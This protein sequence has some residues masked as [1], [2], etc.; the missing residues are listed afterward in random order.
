MNRSGWR[1]T[2]WSK[3]IYDMNIIFRYTSKKD[4]LLLLLSAAVIL[5]QVFVETWIPSQMADISN[6][7]QQPGTGFDSVRNLGLSMLGAAFTAFALAVV[8]MILLSIVGS[9][10][11]GQVRKALFE[12][13]IRFSQ[14]DA[15]NFGTGSLINRATNDVTVVQYFIS[16]YFQPLI[17][18]PLTLFIVFQRMMKGYPVWTWL[19]AV[20]ILVLIGLLA[21]MVAAALPLV[22]TGSNSRD[23]IATLSRE[24]VIGIR[25][26]H[27]CNSYEHQKAEYD[28]VNDELTKVMQKSKK[29]LAVFSPTMSSLLFGLSVAIYISGAFIINRTAGAGRTAVYSDMIEFVSYIALL[30]SALINLAMIILYFPAAYNSGRRIREVLNTRYSIVDPEV[31]VSET[32]EKGTVEFRHVSFRYGKSGENVLSDLS[33]RVGSGETL[34]II[35]G[36]GSG[37]TTVLNLIPRLYD[38]TEGEVLVDGVNVKEFRQNELRNRIGYVPQSN[39][40][41]GGSIG[42]NIGY[43]ENGRFKASLEA[44]EEA[45]KTGQADEFIQKKE[46]TYA[47]QLQPSG[48]NLSGG[49]KQRLTISRAICRDPEIYIF[50]DSFSALDYKTDARLRKALKEKAAG[51]TTII[52]GQRIGVVKKADRIL[53]MDK[54]RIVGQGTHDELMESCQVYREIALSQLPAEV[55]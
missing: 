5:V 24:H 27:S 14:A 2:D 18:T 10:V 31:P 9:N 20:A 23:R 12:K 29:I 40:L 16:Q 48:S 6:L 3:V 32:R 37:K 55:S 52:V 13:E 15:V 46:G 28:G 49:Q 25:V 4:K 50:D 21:Y 41:F 43:G 39:F 33:F 17:Q 53:V 35:G 36:T 45:A 22:G 19:G 34:A 8:G 30:I 51:A 44:I 26:I 38:V 7:I 1:P 54:G 42:Y 11:S 47:Y